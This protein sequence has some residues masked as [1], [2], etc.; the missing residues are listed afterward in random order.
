M[1]F[2]W[3]PEPTLRR[4]RVQVKPPKYML[5][6][7]SKLQLMEIT[8]KKVEKKMHIAEVHMQP[9]GE[10]KDRKYQRAL[11]SADL[12]PTSPCLHGSHDR[13]T[14]PALEPPHPQCHVLTSSSLT[15]APLATCLFS[16]LS[17]SLTVRKKCLLFMSP[18]FS[19]KWRKMCWYQYLRNAALVVQ[20]ATAT[21]P[22]RIKCN[23]GVLEHKFG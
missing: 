3:F 19:L 17:D 22:L 14:E 10:M 23:D 1:F 8:A 12:L 5:A 18:V 2:Y 16:S 15:H 7:L 6:F 20:W 21:R 11:V 13:A 9:E 4:H